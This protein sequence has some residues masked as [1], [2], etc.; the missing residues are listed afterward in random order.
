MGQAYFKMKNDQEAEKYFR[1]AIQ[2]NPR[3]WMPHNFLG[4]IYD[5]RQQ[6]SAAVEEYRA[7]LAI[8]PDE[9]TVCNNLGVSYSLAGEYEKAVEAFS[10]GLRIKP[11]DAKLGNNLGLVLLKLGRHREAIE[12]FKV[13]GDEAQA[14][15]NLGV[16]YLEQGEYE[17][18][19]RAFE[20]A[21][22]LRS[23]YYPQA[24]ENLKKAEIGYSSS[25]GPSLP[26]GWKPEP[27]RDTPVIAPA[28]G[29]LGT[30]VKETTLPKDAG[31]P[32]DAHAAE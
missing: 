30:E 14:Y 20:R 31:T 2:S 9:T 10:Q 22:A 4:L 5:D 18:A 7:A 11:R 17:K 13:S 29:V 6:Y 3:L 26:E 28:S 27:A 32:G 15:N 25:I 23:E 8:K 16:I 1:Q 24:Q 21:I 19:V 12:A